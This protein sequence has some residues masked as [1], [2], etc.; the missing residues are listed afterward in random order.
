MRSILL[1]FT[2]LM[3]WAATIAAAAADDWADCRLSA[4]ERR[5]AAC[6]RLINKKDESRENLA[7]AYILRGG[8]YRNR[9]DTE[10][11]LTDYN[12]AVRLDPKRTPLCRGLIHA[13]KK[14]Y[15]NAISQFTEAI[16]LDA[17]DVLAYN[18]RGNAYAGKG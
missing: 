11:A 7:L 14:E 9:N 3:I 10:K 17:R 2:A 16:R 5:V 12:S 8:A 6:T 13:T 15:D 1:A 18:S 4:P